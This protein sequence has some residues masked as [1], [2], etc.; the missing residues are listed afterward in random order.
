MATRKY[1][2]ALSTVSIQFGQCLN[3]I[4]R[5]EPR[6]PIK[7]QVPAFT[8]SSSQTAIAK[9][10]ASEEKYLWIFESLLTPEGV[11]TLRKIQALQ[12]SQLETKTFTGII[13]TDEVELYREIAASPTRQKTAASAT[14]EGDGFISYYAKFKVG[15]AIDWKYN[16]GAKFY[17]PQITLT[18]L[19]KYT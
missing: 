7:E 5:A 4:V 19:D 8:Y 9:A 18:E 3:S 1:T 10:A 16:T 12:R 11:I 17:Q 6:I 13:L 2:L 14:S 15:M